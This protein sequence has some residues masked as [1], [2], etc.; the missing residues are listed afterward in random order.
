LA[1]VFFLV[2][3]CDLFGDD[4]YCQFEAKESKIWN[5]GTNVNYAPGDTCVSFVFNRGDNV[6][7]RCFQLENVCPLGPLAVRITLTE[8]DSILPPQAKA[9]KA[10]LVEVLPVSGFYR[11]H[12][13][14]PLYRQSGTTLRGQYVFL[15][16]GLPEN[17][18]REFFVGVS[19]VF[20]EGEF[21]DRLKLEDWAQ[22]HVS[23]VVFEADFVRWK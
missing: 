9:Y 17:G 4:E 22:S 18:P 23:R 13:I 16:A 20:Y 11:V 5:S 15:M 19:A 1:Y 2:G 7:Q 12:E 3:G 8:K 21:S 14:I 10:L 6:S